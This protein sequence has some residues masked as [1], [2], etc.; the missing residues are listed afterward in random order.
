M[1]FAQPQTCNYCRFLDCSIPTLSARSCWVFS[2]RLLQLA[3]LVRSWVVA[4]VF[5]PLFVHSSSIFSAGFSVSATQTYA[6]CTSSSYPSPCVGDPKFSNEYTIEGS[7]ILTYELQETILTPIPPMGGSRNWPYAFEYQ[8]PTGQWEDAGWDLWHNF[9][10]S[11]FLLEER[12][13]D[14]LDGQPYFHT[15]KYK[16]TNGKSPLGRLLVYPHRNYEAY[17][18]YQ[19]NSTVTQK[20]TWE[21]GPPEQPDLTITDISQSEQCQG[22]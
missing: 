4:C 8:T 10:G 7:G 21:P 20:L 6:E 18:F 2:G 3:T 15:W 16:V 22:R 19:I 11:R 1:L 13:N 14:G 9:S 5:V 12:Y 17:G